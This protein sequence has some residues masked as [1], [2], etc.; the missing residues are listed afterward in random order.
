MTLKLTAE[1]TQKLC[2]DIWQKLVTNEKNLQKILRDAG[3]SKIWVLELTKVMMLTQTVSPWEHPVACLCKYLDPVTQGRLS[4]LI[5]TVLLIKKVD[6]LTLDQ[7]LTVHVPHSV[8]DL[9][10]Y[11]G[12][13]CKNCHL[14]TCGDNVLNP[15]TYLSTERRPTDH[16]FLVLIKCSRVNQP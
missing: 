16:H 12:L 11:Q 3:F 10:Q 13:D 15:A 9:T 5:A 8:L 2:Y 7:D 14:V 6:K 1:K 4:T